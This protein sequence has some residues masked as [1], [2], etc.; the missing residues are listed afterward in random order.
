MKQ[1]IVKTGRYSFFSFMAASILF[2]LISTSSPER[3]FAA[4]PA[5]Y[6][7]HCGDGKVDY[8][9]IC[10]D[11]NRVNGDG[12]NSICQKESATCIDDVT[13]PTNLNQQNNCTANDVYLALVLNDKPLVCELGTTFEASLT[14]KFSG[15]ATMR[16]DVGMFIALDEGIARRGICYRDFLHPVFGTCSTTDYSPG[17]IGHCSAP[18]SDIECI[19]SYQCQIDTC[20]ESTA[21]GKKCSISGTVCVTDGDCS[22][23]S[24]LSLSCNGYSPGTAFYNAECSDQEDVCGDIL[25]N[26]PNYYDIPTKLTLYCIDRED[27]VTHLKDGKADL[28]SC[29]SWDNQ[30]SPCKS[31]SYIKPAEKSKCKCAVTPIGNVYVGGKIIVDKVTDPAGRS[32]K[33]DFTLQGGPV[34]N[35][36]DKSFQLADA[37]SPYDSGALKPSTLPGETDNPANYYSVDETTLPSGW[38]KKSV[39]CTSDNGTKDDAI[40]DHSVVNTAINLHSGEIV[41][42]NFTNQLQQGTLIVKKHV[43]NDNGGTATADN[44]S[45]HVKNSATEV[46]GSPQAGS[47]IGTS[48]TLLPGAYN[49]S[50]TGGVS[51]YSFKNFSGDCSSS[52]NVTVEPGETKTC[53][54]TNDDKAPALHLR[55]VV[56][57]DNGGTAAVVDFTL[58]A[59]GPTPLSGASP[60]DSG[61]TFSAGTYTLSEELSAAAAGKYDASAWSCVK[62]GGTAVEGGSVTL[63]NGDEATCTITNDD[64]P[65]TIII[66]KIIKGTATSTGFQFQTTGDGYN[67]F[68]LNGGDQN[69]QTL[70]AGQ[71]S[72]KELTGQLSWVLTGIGGSTDVNTPYNCVVTGNGGSTGIGDLMTQTATINLKNGDTVTC[73]FENTGSG[74][75]RTQGF[76]A[77]HPQLA[78]IAW[79]GGSRFGHTF[80]GVATVSGIGDQLIKGKTVTSTMAAGKNQLMGGFWSAIAKTSKGTKRS[81]LDQARLQLL[82]QLLAAELNASAFGSV[83]SGGSA[84]FKAWEAAISGTDQKKISTAQQQAA[85]FNSQGDSSTFTPGTSADSKTARAYADIP[86]W[87]TF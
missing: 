7:P 5:P 30:V 61:T 65:G 55:K 14:A 44:W 32:E 10:D 66:K 50:E 25:K 34:G 59:V 41:T 23:P 40:D 15:T 86:F 80:P 13:F 69:S 81:A 28:A 18:H 19:S 4:D 62:N 22:A 21:G 52:G 31:L 57:N 20:L 74:A 9:E 77:T 87:N 37:D 49:V 82:Q 3:I 11:G 84:M 60:V 1:H 53:T 8:D 67:G 72:V 58:K 16:Y 54:I 70:S 64:K 68:T 83:P 6:P 47:E 79:N 46:T 78:E 85:A 75:T 63:A 33:F 48:Y 29:L 36:V 2:A 39:V 24:N 42:C 27:S 35:T 56:T 12:C 71:Y 76:W 38:S 73:T 45:I 51:G 43:V 26:V 17:T